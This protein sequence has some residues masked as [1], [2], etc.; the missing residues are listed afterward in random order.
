MMSIALSTD[1]S[2]YV[3]SRAEFYSSSQCALHLCTFFR[4]AD[5]RGERRGL[6]RLFG[7]TSTLSVRLGS[8]RPVAV[9]DPTR[10]DMGC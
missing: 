3:S 8:S 5:C 2:V 6:A 4:F 10:C 1:Y 7:V 9:V